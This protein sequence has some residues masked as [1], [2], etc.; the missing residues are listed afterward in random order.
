MTTLKRTA[1][2]IIE[3]IA[4]HY[5]FTKDREVA[6]KLGISAAVIANWKRRDSIDIILIAERCEDL[7]INNL[8]RGK[9]LEAPNQDVIRLPHHGKSVAEAPVEYK[10]FKNSDV[11]QLIKDKDR[12]II[13]LAKQ[14]GEWELKYKELKKQ[15]VQDK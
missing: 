11:F 5:G 10:Q 4:A 7:D 13:S 6:E 1:T 9:P 12:T 3:A 8:L 2:E 15:N 14:L